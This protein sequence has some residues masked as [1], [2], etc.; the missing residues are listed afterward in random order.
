MLSATHTHTGPALI[1]ESALD[2]LVG[3]TSDLGERHLQ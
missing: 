2:D 1:R 3:A